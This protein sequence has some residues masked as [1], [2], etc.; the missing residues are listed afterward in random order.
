MT[1]SAVDVLADALRQ[2]QQ[3]QSEAARRLL[4]SAAA[5]SPDSHDVWFNK[6][7]ADNGAHL[8]ADAA[9]SF[10]RAGALAPQSA[11]TFLN[12]G[13]IEAQQ[14]RFK[15]A[16]AIMR[17]AVL[18]R[19]SYHKARFAMLQTMAHDILS[20]PPPPPIPAPQ[21]QI[22][23]DDPTISVVVCSVT[24]EKLAK[25]RARY[26]ALLGP[27]YEFLAI[28]DAKSLCEA[29]NRAMAQ[30]R[31]DVLIFSHDD[32]DI[33]EPDFRRRLLNHLRRYDM[34]GPAGAAQLTGASWIDSGA[35]YSAGVVV[36]QPTPA[37]PFRVD[38]YGVRAAAE[39]VQALDGLFIAVRRAVAEAVG[40][41]EETFDGF[42][43]YDTDFTFRAHLAGYRLA[44]CSDLAIVH[45]SFGRRDAVWSLYAG[46][47]IEKHRAALPAL[48]IGENPARFV[49][50]KTPEQTLAFLRA[51]VDGAT[52]PPPPGA[53][54]AQEL[55]DVV[56]DP[57]AEL[58]RR[59]GAPPAKALPG[60]RRV[61]HVGCGPANPLKLNP[62]FRNDEWV[63]IRL[64][65]DPALKPDI[66]AS[67]SDLSALPSG[68]VDAVWSSHNLEHLYDHEVIPALREFLR[69]LRVGGLLLMTL[70]DLQAVAR[71]IAD[72]DYDRVLATSVDGSAAITPLDVVFG[73]RLLIE[74]GRTYM[75]H[76]TGF[77]M[78]RLAKTIQQAGFGQITVARGREFDLWAL[79]VN[80]LEPPASDLLQRAMA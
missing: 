34:V 41:D 51:L 69:V 20:S 29:Y 3:N 22:L 45:Q 15:A 38:V 70:P 11:E 63:E 37:H 32:L 75:A 58:L 24:P 1:N 14:G 33:L 65:I 39:P 23:P 55:P 10:R 66:V 36:H 25:V 56:A 61:L 19:P 5:L 44:A 31:G 76:R 2:L 35:P 54:K 80:G 28:T 68:S 13:L 26:D 43:C 18:A 53:V 40:F 52:A 74:Q 8:L 21:P 79:A 12:L 48:F 77:T 60:K 7:V 42:H 71:H 57:F 9:A 78:T 17:R 50:M 59:C 72:D 62:V 73:W 46:R 27:D 47:F 6:G 64:D 67:I 49:E 4:R 30:T 16:A